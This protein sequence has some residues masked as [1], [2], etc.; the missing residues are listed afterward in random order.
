M[1]FDAL[2]NDLGVIRID[3]VAEDVDAS[4]PDISFVGG[5]GSGKMDL[6][7]AVLDSRIVAKA[8]SLRE[9]EQAGIELQRC[10]EIGNVK[11]G[12]GAVR[13]HVVEW[14]DRELG[15]FSDTS[16]AS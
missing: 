4:L 5:L 11:G 14:R 8:E 3:V 6:D 16:L 7:F 9:A 15:G 2:C 12:R 10:G 13:F 1:C